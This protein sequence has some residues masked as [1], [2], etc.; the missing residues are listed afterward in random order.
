MFYIINDLDR[1]CVDLLVYKD[2]N[3][4]G[5]YLFNRSNRNQI[6]SKEQMKE[7]TPIERFGFSMK[8]KSDGTLIFEKTSQSAAKYA[9][10]KLRNW[11]DIE[12]TNCFEISIL[13]LITGDK[14]D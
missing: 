8:T 12:N 11:Q 13:Q 1:P 6:F 4:C 7:A 9:D 14:N 2:K 10:G 3:G 5:H